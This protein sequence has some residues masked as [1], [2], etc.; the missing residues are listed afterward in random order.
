[1]CDEMGQLEVFPDRA[2]LRRKD[3]SRNM[4]RFYLMAVQRDLFGRASLIREW[5]RIG[6][7]G[8]LCVEHHPDEG[9]AVDALSALMAAKR[10][11]GYAS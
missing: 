11:R 5:G 7:P 4:H 2:Y 8:K 9:R 10:K 6:S 3:P 1:M